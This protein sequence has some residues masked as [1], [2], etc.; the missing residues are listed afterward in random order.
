[1]L[2]PLACLKVEG[3]RSQCGFLNLTVLWSLQKELLCQQIGLSPSI[4]Q[5]AFEDAVLER[6]DGDDFVLD[7][8]RW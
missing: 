7:A 5:D 3:Q 4:S 6:V 8:L 1:M 2:S